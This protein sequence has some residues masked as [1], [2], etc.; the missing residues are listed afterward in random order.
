M[1]GTY[2]FSPLEHYYFDDKKNSP[3]KETIRRFHE[4]AT[5]LY[6]RPQTNITSQRYMK[7]LNTRDMSLNQVDE[8]AP[9]DEDLKIP[10]YL[11]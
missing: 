1:A 10:P 6:E 9:N 4:R 3:C 2:Q 8:P 5:A 11:F 7:S